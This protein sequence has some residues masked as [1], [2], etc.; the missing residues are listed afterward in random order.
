MGTST[1]ETSILHIWADCN[2]R[3]YDG[4]KPTPAHVVFDDVD[5]IRLEKVRLFSFD[6]SAESG[7]C[8]ELVVPQTLTLAAASLVIPMFLATLS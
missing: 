5:S 8:L 7:S 4:M 2:A 6:H 3:L 1:F